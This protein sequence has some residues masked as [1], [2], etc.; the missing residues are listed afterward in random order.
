[1]TEPR[2]LELARKDEGLTEIPGESSAARIL[3]MARAIGAPAWYH[4]DDQPWCAVAMNAW[5]LEAGQPLCVG[6][7][8]DAFDRLRALTFTDYGRSL[9]LPALGAIGVFSRPEGAHVALYLGEFRDRYYV[10]GGNQHNQVCA[11]WIEKR[12]LKSWRWPPL[13]PMPIDF[14]RI[15]RSST[16]QVVTSVNEA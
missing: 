16:G 14:R 7:R 10:F 6:A 9:A 12:R 8:G 11:T 13:G 4:N 5:L 3:A 2:W 1:M 15:V